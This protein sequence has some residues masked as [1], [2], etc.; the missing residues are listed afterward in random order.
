MNLKLAA[1]ALLGTALAPQPLLAQDASDLVGVWSGAIEED[2]DTYEA[3]VA[4]D[5]DKDGDPVGRIDY[6]Q[7][8]NGV[9]LPTQ[10]QGRAWRFD[11]TITEGRELC[12]SHVAVA[13][14]VTDEG[15]EV[16]LR[17]VGFDGIATGV[18]TRID[19]GSYADAAAAAEEAADAAEADYID[20]AL[21]NPG[22]TGIDY[23]QAAQETWFI[24]GDPIR[25]S[26]RRFAKYGLPRVL[27]RSDVA[28]YGYYADAAVFVEADGDEY[29]A[30]EV[31]Y[32]L[33][34]PPRNSREEGACEFQ[35]YQA[36]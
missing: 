10:R 23:G 32:V 18:L 26:G 6:S 21:C 5:L 16:E 2:G 19:T 31:I 20:A 29:S 34:G 24:R 8:C 28:A 17:P 25:V 7:P 14:Q 12:A 33:V 4:I 13:L 22:E 27:S 3:W 15:L 30:P 1:A 35:P 11:E 36:E 9:W